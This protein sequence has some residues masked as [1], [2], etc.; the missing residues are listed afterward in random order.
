[1][2]VTRR[3]RECLGIGRK[4]AL[5]EATEEPH[6]REIHLAMAAVRGRIDEA[7]RALLVDVQVASPEIAV[8]ACRW[9]LRTDEL[10]EPGEQALEAA[11]HG[12]RRASRLARATHL[13]LEPLALEK[14]RP[15]HMRAVRLREAA[16][17]VVVVEP[18]RRRR[19]AM[20]RR[21]RATELLVEAP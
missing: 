7:R 12:G 11:P 8:Q 19:R 17:E 9:F 6:H 1:L 10:V 14:I 20:E 18:E 4:H 16:D 3:E 5:A 2:G 21:E 15:A 13:W